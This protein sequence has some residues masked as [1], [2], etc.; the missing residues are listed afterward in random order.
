MLSKYHIT[1]LGCQMNKNDSERIGGL[2]SGT[3]MEVADSANEADVLLINTCSVRQS[4]EDRV[5]GVVKNWQ[6]LRQRRPEL[7]VCVTGCLP[8]RDKDGKLR[9]KF[10]GVDLFFPID[11]LNL[12]PK[13]LLSLNRDLFADNFDDHGDY[14]NVNPLRVNNISASITIQTGCDNFCTYCAVPYARGRERNRV[15]RDIL[16]EIKQAAASGIKE[17]V[18]LGQVVNNFKIINQGNP[19]GDGFTALLREVNQIDGVERL[20][21]TAADPQYFN[22]EQI[23]ALKLSKQ[24]NYLHL[25]V[26]SGDNEILRKMKRKYTRESYIGLIKKIRVAR[27]DIAIGTDLIVGFCGETD[28]QFNN[29]LDLYRQCDFDIAYQAKYSERAGTVAAKTF[30]DDV[31]REI[32]KQRWQAVQD[33]M[34]ETAYRKNQKYVGRIVMVLVDKC[35]KNICSGNSSEMKLTQFPGELDLIGQ[36]VP[37]KIDWADTWVLRGKVV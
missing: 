24:I 1:T 16:E 8:G 33:L 17:V 5:F 34:E 12:L 28:E 15:V 31:P 26:Q 9:K 4:A 20:H 30:K 22:D 3:G 2:L 6:E 35:E 37:V 29:T 36:I 11:E 19:F 7:I 21:W 14:L 13:R 23:E 10:P 27:P 18:L 25:P 32:K